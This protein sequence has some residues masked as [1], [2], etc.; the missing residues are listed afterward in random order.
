MISNNRFDKLN[1]RW[2]LFLLPGLLLGQL[3]DLARL[4]Y[5]NLPSLSTDFEFV[6]TR[7]LVNYP[8][9]LDGKGSYLL[10]GLDYSNINL[11]LGNGERPFEQREIDGFQIFDFNIGYTAK[12]N[13]DWR[14]GVRVVP[15]FSSNLSAQK[16]GFDDAVLSGDLVFI[17]D[18]KSSPGIDTPFRLIVGLSYGGNRGFPYPLPFISYYRKFHPKWSYNLGIPKTNLQY[19]IS[20]KHRMKANLQL[21]GFT[22]NIQNGLSL[23]TGQVAESINMSS[24][25]SGL[26]YEFHFSEHLEFFLRSSYIIV[27]DLQLRDGQKDNILLLDNS[28]GL[29]LRTAIRL[30]I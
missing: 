9:K 1:V 25:L 8:I 19:H 3:S 23:T 14:F 30:K 24:I 28:H 15:G 2:V 12:I 18:K 17:K 16:L 13:E 10:I 27:R 6:R 26:Q 29:S 4:E 20:E 7:A 22:A 5:T 11:I 21:D